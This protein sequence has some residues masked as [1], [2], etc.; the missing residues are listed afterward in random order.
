MRIFIARFSFRQ[1]Q[2]LFITISL[3]NAAKER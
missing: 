2:F 1:R 3:Y